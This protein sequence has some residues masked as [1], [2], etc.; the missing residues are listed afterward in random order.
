MAKL[1]L[2]P[3]DVSPIIIPIELVS[4]LSGG[5]VLLTVVSAPGEFPP[6][7]PQAM[8]IPEATTTNNIL[9]ISFI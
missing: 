6:P 4:G 9:F 3:I 8:K 2:I 7:F 1:S 5:V